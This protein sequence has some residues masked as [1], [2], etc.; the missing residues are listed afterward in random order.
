MPWSLW[1]SAADLRTIFTAPDKPTA[2]RLAREAADRW[3]ES[4]SK[5]TEQLEEN[6]EQ[7][8]CC[9]AFPQSHQRRIRN[10]NGLE[11]FNQ[12]LARRSRVVRIFP[13]RE[14]CLRLASALAAETSEEWITGKRYLNMDELYEVQSAEP[15]GQEVVSMQR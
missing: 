7:C 4:H 14:S 15:A 10:T 5:V 2:L 1:R 9:L 13:N 11:R 8:L 12:E 6:I 3:T